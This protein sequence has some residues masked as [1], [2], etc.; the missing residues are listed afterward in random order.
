[1]PTQ[2]QID[3]TGTIQPTIIV[4]AD[5]GITIEINSAPAV[6]TGLGITA[7]IGDVT[8][9]GPGIAVA[10][11]ATVNG[12]VGTFGSATQVAQFT[13]NGKGLVTGVANVTVT[14]AVGSITG[15]GTG[16]ATS[17]GVNVGTDGAFVVKGGVLGTPSSG[18][19]ANCTFPATGVVAGAYTAANITVD[20]SGRI[21]AAANGVGGGGTVTSVSVVTADGISGS[22]AT[23]TTTPAI[24]LTLGAITPSSIVASGTI[25]G[26]NLSGTNTGDQTITLTGD[27]TGSGT[28]SFAA[29]LANTAVTPGSYTNTNLT[30]DSKGRITA[31]SNGSAGAGNVTAAGTLTANAIVLGAGTTAVTVLGSLGTT[32]TVLHGNAAGA[33]TFGAVSLTADV[34]G[35]LAAGNGGT[36]ITSLGTGVA[37][38][39]GTPSSANLAA[40]VTGETGTGALVFGTAPT[41]ATKITV[42]TNASTTGSIDI[43][44]TTSG[45]V[46]IKTADAAGTWTLTLPTTDGTNLQFLQTD[47]NGVTT[48]ATASGTG[49]VIGPATNTADFVPQWNGANS[50]TLKDGLAT[51]AGGVGSSDAG[52]IVLFGASGHLV[53]NNLIQIESSGDASYAA[54]GYTAFQFSDGSDVFTLHCPVTID[55]HDV[56]LPN[57]D[58]TI[59]LDTDLGTNVAAWLATPSSANLAAAMTNETG[60]GLLVFGTSPVFTTD[61]TLPNGASPT[62]GSVAKVAFDTDAWAASRGAIQVHDGTANTFVVAT[63]ASDTP[64]NGQVPTW[65]TG[66]TI[67]WETPTG[68]VPTAITVANE[69][70]DTTCFPLFVTAA[71]GDLGPKSNASLTFNSNTASLACTTFVGALTGN[72]STAT[73]L[74]T[75]RTIGGVTFDGTGNIVPQTIQ[76]VNEATDTT[77]FP[78]FIS[79][80]GTQSLQPLNNTGL[81]FDSSTRTLGLGVASGATGKINLLGTTSGVVTLSV[82]DAAGTWTMKLP[83]SAGSNTNVLQTD[84]SGNTS[85]VAAGGGSGGSTNIWVPASAMIPRVTNGAGVNSSETTT[86]DINYDSLDFDAT[87]SEGAQFW[88]VMPNNWTPGTVTFKPYWTAD[89]GSGTFISSVAARDFANDDALDTAVGTPQTSTDT[90]ITAGDMHIGPASSAITIAGTPANGDAICFQVTRDV[91]DTLNADARLIGIE[92]TFS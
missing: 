50:K 76:S 64:S 83:T 56:F 88:V 17:L 39:L 46:T 40:A 78:L 82:A 47:G 53:A 43:V 41:F 28:G 18:N 72:A 9:T 48:W 13:V 66:G 6:S 11:L 86:N 12:N 1:M 57:A 59:L 37:T 33:P 87:T 62:T 35:T 15:L 24:T 67:T 38:W 91:S 16:V 30:V 60:S 22:V 3:V 77:C 49:D 7:L 25:A 36:G 79:A 31:A 80:S 55:N 34:T 92:V 74:A 10:T 69:A 44:G 81:T 65:N 27:V 8:A 84:G 75:G 29:T 71:T 21:T 73:A 19:L 63:L 5:G 51:S 32:S 61:I 2:P 68:G 45:I 89:S 20:A 90:L 14:P 70:T 23:A 58:G 42:G 85:W 26:S 4:E 54:F 52:K